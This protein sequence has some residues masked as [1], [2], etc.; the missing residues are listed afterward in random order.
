MA[1]SGEADLENKNRKTH[2]GETIG[3]TQSHDNR[4][5]FHGRGRR[6]AGMGIKIEHRTIDK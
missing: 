6:A 3:S 2:K 5:E 1:S 4:A